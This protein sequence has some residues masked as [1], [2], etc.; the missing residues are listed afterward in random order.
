MSAGL[1]PALDDLLGAPAAG[2]AR[3]VVLHRARRHFR[4]E[5]LAEAT[6]ALVFGC[7]ALPVLAVLVALGAAAGGVPLPGLGDLL[8]RAWRWSREVEVQRRGGDGAVLQRAVLAPPGPDAADAGM[9]ALLEHAAARGLVVLEAT[10]APRRA[11]IAAWYGGQPWM[12]PPVTPDLP[13]CNRI[14]A[15]TGRVE[16]GPDGLRISL[17]E[18]RPAP[19]LAAFGVVFLAPALCWTAAGRDTLR[20]LFD[21]ARA[22]PAAL[23]VHLS[24]SALHFARTR[25]EHVLW[26]DALPRAS[27][28]GLA[29]APAP[30]R[31]AV[32]PREGPHLR[33]HARGRSLHVPVPGGEATGP[34]LLSVLATASARM[35]GAPGSPARIAACPRCA[36]RYAF[37]PEARCPACG[38]Q[39]VQL[40]GLLDDAPAAPSPKV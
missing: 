16:D 36:T 12:Q 20:T 23:R 27:L 15:R 21:D 1:G 11:P 14:L 7:G 19:W 35:D 2:V 30:E 39:P 26:E 18:R 25:G 37:A 9:R 3:L 38:T 34:A 29:F 4:W 22:R 13:A 32:P 33:V 17:A 31:G 5:A 24:R 6:L 10:D 28:L 40:D 8:A